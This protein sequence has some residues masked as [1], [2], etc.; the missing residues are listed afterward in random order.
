MTGGAGAVVGTEA[1]FQ[2]GVGRVAG[3]AGELALAGAEAAAG[4]QE[5]G[6]VAGVPGVAK[7]G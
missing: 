1:G 3:E 2:C 5:Q 6:L 4:G 7:V